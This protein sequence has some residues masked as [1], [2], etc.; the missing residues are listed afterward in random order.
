[1][2]DMVGSYIFGIYPR[3]EKLI[4]IT[5][6]RTYAPPDFEEESKVLFDS[7]R[8]AELTYVQ[9]PLLSWDDMFRP[10][11][12][13]SNG[14][15][16][17]GINRFF[18]TNTFYRVPLL[19]GD[20]DAKEDVSARS[21]HLG[22]YKPEDK[23]MAS[24]PDPLTFAILSKDEHYGDISLVIAA[25]GELLSKQARGLNRAGFESLVLKCPAYGFIDLKKHFDSLAEAI[26]S[27]K[28]AFI[29]KVIL[30][31]YFKPVKDVELLNELPVDGLGFDMINGSQPLR[32]M[33]NKELALGLVNGYSTVL[34]EDIPERVKAILG[35]INPPKAY[36]TNNVD[37]EY[38]PY[39]FAIKK[40]DLLRKAMRRINND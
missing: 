18:E 21:L 20:I 13:N 24:L 3:S 31:I 37:L 12:V 9:D 17:D 35:S 34:E 30:H 26:S 40:L 11:T 29:K 6:K 4:E 39:K 23:R 8:E 22:L 5:R 2:I 28:R 25:M 14:I 27:I 10:I 1:M 16:P 38:V 19:E 33:D 36:V 32:R 15:K 7:Q